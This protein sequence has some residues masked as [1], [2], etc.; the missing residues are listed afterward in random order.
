MRLYRKDIIK[1]SLVTLILLGLII[2]WLGFGDRGFIHLYRMDKERQFYQEKIQK[3]EEANLKL[4]DEIKRLRE[5][6]EYIESIA[7]KEFGLIKEDE[8]IYRF[9][10]SQKDKTNSDNPK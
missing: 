2:A 4:L 3:L 9:D 8:L 5:D 10:E 1:I 6:D 7:R